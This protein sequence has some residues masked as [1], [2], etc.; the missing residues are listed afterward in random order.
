[1]E[2]QRFIYK[3]HSSRLEK[4]KWNLTLPIEEARNNDEIISLASSQVLRWIDEINGVE[5]ADRIAGDIKAKIRRLRNGE[6]ST[7]NRREMRRLYGELDKIQYKKDYMCLIIDK[8]SHYLRACKGFR[9]NGV[10]YHRLLAT[11][12][13]V[14]NSTI[15]FVSDNVRDELMRRI[16]NGRDQSKAMVPA[17]LES[18]K[19]LS[20]SASIPVS[21][22]NGIL[23]VPDAETTF[24]TDYIYLSD[25]NEGE[26][27]IENRTNEEVTIDATDGFGLM[28]PSL[29]ERWS[30]ELGLGYTMCGCNTRA[31]F[32]KGM[33]FSFD[34]LDFAEHVAGTFMVRDA[35]GNDVDVRNVELVLTTS[36]LKLWDSY[37]SCEEY[38]RISKENGY[39]IGI[40]KVCPKHLES[41][42]HLN[43]QFIQSFELD[44]NDIMELISPTIQE[45]KDVLSEDWRKSI[46]F[47]KGT[48]LT[49]DNI[50]LVENDY[51]KAIMIDERV[52]DDPFVQNSIYQMISNKINEAKVGVIKVH[53]NYSIVS[54]DPFLL[55]QSIFGMEKTGLLKAG[56][57]YN[58]YWGKLSTEE[59]VCFRA[60]MSTAENI[61]KMKPARGDEVSYWYRYMNACTIL[62]AWDTSMA[63]LNGCD[64]DGD[65][66]MITDNDVLVRKYKK[67]PALMCIQRKAEKKVPTEMDFVTS[68]IATFGNEIGQTTNWITSMYEV[69]SKYEPGSMEYDALSYRIRC[70]QLYQQNTIDKTKGIIAKPMPRYW[71]DRHV[72][73]R[74]DECDEKEFQKRVVADRKPYFM[75]Y[76]YPDLMKE[77][78][79]YT[80]NVDRNC[81]RRF[82][83]TVAELELMPADER[84]DEENE[85]LDHYY[86]KLPV[87][88][89]PCVMNKI[90]KIFEREFDGYVSRKAKE[91]DFDYSFMKSDAEYTLSQYNSIKSLYKEYNKRLRDYAMFADYERIQDSDAYATAIAMNEEFRKECDKI[92]PDKRALCNI[93]LD[94]CYIKSSTK[95]FAWNMCGSE[96]I[97][98]LLDNNG[99]TIT[100]PEQDEYGDIEYAGMRFSTTEYEL[101]DWQ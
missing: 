85:F 91:T 100:F 20:C 29:A 80:R 2:Q 28:L 96:I 25:E 14:K 15:I 30:K 61:I 37:S 24:R 16:E 6:N 3:I 58:N 59:V 57:I 76:I 55:C 53:G 43:Y 13:G 98:N 19:A 32:S 39:M 50:D 97:Q 72:V 79:T 101:E 64:F 18:Y 4:A 67:Y 42:R 87:G 26:P 54:G 7:Q 60:P 93:I 82:E 69:R 47:L 92:C 51:A 83:K 23:V 17:K 11:N 33:V 95:R 65:L 12:G 27:L 5:D 52:A 49:I 45:F 48:G 31:P 66:L 88:T 74:M 63:A 81:L 1:M 9:I 10:T 90:C 34:F 36:M 99:N 89:G 62:N 78:N 73:N 77:Y 46:L 75:R 68:N 38:V 94:I 71:H 35:W 44:D 8:K 84:T 86:Y 56:E 41:E 40:P 70:G 21:W 22:P